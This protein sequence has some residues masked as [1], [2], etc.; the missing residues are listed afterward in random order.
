M[1]TIHKRR[2]ILVACGLLAGALSCRSMQNEELRMRIEIDVYSGRPNPEFRL[3]E[4]L[5]RELARMLQD[6][7]RPDVKRRNRVWVTVVSWLVRREDP[8]CRP[9]CASSMDSSSTKMRS[10]PR[11]SSTARVRKPG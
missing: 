9:G 6:F 3:S 8:A 7:P 10:R 11:L 4:P 2:A 1:L 5:S